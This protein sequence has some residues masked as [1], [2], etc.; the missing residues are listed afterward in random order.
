[1]PIKNVQKNKV[2]GMGKVVVRKRLIPPLAMLVLM[3]LKAIMLIRLI[4]WLE[5]MTSETLKTANSQIK[6][7]LNLQR[8]LQLEETK[9]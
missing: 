3:T 2:G 5:R 8:D 4:I 1:M 6:M 7:S 9:R